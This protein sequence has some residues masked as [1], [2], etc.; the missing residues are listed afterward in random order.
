MT[1]YRAKGDSDLMAK[2]ERLAEAFQDAGLS[3]MIEGPV[4]LRESSSGR[5]FHLLDLETDVGRLERGGAYISEFP[6]QLEYKLCW[7]KEEE[8]Q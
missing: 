4:M 1:W 8:G 5:M 6:P 2:L 7:E 3:L